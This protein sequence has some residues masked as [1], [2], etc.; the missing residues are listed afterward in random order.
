VTRETRGPRVPQ[1]NLFT[2][3]ARG[4]TPPIPA[5]YLEVILIVFIVVVWAAVGVGIAVL[6]GWRPSQGMGP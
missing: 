6:F 4:F 1:V 3:P 5:R 2:Q